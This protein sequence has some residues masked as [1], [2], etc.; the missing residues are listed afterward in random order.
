MVAFVG[1]FFPFHD[2][3]GLSWGSSHVSTP[4]CSISSREAEG[5]YH[6]SLEGRESQLGAQHPDTLLSVH[7]LAFV[8]KQQGKL[9][10]AGQDKGL[11]SF[12]FPSFTGAISVYEKFDFA[13]GTRF[14]KFALTFNVR[15]HCRRR[16]WWNDPTRRGP[17]KQDVPG[18]QTHEPVSPESKLRL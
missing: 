7:N 9:E 11:V 6:R 8:L 3:G 1:L 4:Q 5:L 16:I 18:S 14:G 2:P 15:Q 10:E 17:S 12:L 13:Y